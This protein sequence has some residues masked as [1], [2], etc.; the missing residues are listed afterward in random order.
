MKSSVSK[1][2][3]HKGFEV[4]NSYEVFP[5][6]IRLPNPA[7]L[8]SSMFFLLFSSDVKPAREFSFFLNGLDEQATN[9]KINKDIKADFKALLIKY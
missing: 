3:L 8:P 2:A 1:E 7:P 5:P 4:L 9:A 6:F